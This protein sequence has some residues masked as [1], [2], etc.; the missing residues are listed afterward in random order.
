ML[1]PSGQASLHP[2]D[3]SAR[4]GDLKLKLEWA[5]ASSRVWPCC[6]WCGC[7]GP[8]GLLVVHTPPLSSMSSRGAPTD[9]HAE[10]PRENLTI[11]HPF[12]LIPVG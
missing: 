11:S 4:P 8:A 1:V 7:E 3:W 12:I 5:L 10:E 2:I 6:L 9:V